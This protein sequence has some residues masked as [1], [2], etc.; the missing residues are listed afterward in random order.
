MHHFHVGHLIQTYGY[1]GV[2]F[3]LMIECIGIPLPAETTLTIAG[4]SWQH[5]MFALL[6][7]M[8]AATLGNVAGSS[9]A[10]WIGRSLGRSVI[11]RFGRYVGITEARLS[12]A[13]EKFHRLQVPV[14]LVAKFIAGIRILVPYLAGINKMNFWAF[15]FYNAISAIVWSGV[16]IVVGRYIVVAWEHYSHLLG[17]HW[18]SVSIVVVLLVVLYLYY[19]R[20]KKQKEAESVSEHE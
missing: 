18:L 15:T 5:G 7:A 3:I 6:P 4:I 8:G 9:I 12:K 2:F 17:K 1:G 14:I 16:F 20:R 13:E 11:L 10:Y 19:K